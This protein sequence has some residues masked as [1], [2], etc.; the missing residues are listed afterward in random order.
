M[1]RRRFRR[2]LPSPRL[3]ARPVSAFRKTGVFQRKRLPRSA[4]AHHARA[5]G[6]R[7]ARKLLQYFVSYPELAYEFGP[8]IAEEFV[9]AED[10]VA[11]QIVE[12]WRAVQGDG[13]HPV[14][15]PQVLL[16]MLAQSPNAP[17]YRELLAREMLI[18]TPLAAARQEINV[19]MNRLELQRIERMLT[20]IAA[21]PNPDLA[22]YQALTARRMAIKAQ[23]DE[24]SQAFDRTAELATL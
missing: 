24:I 22:R 23:I 2:V 18:E 9:D 1:R 8:R 19:A 12:V 20:D 21:S 5:G 14:D 13:D 10:P 3:T 11:Q 7:H 17:Y 16:E 15:K 6:G 4:A